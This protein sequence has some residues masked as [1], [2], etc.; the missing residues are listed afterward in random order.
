MKNNK[1]NFYCVQPI[2]IDK[3]NYIKLITNKDTNINEYENYLD[4]DNEML[5]LKDNRYYSSEVYDKILNINLKLKIDNE[6]LLPDINK[7]KEKYD[8]IEDLDME[9]TKYNLLYDMKLK[10][11]L[12]IR[13]I[14]L[15][16]K[17]KSEIKD[18]H[19]DFYNDIR[20][21]LVKETDECEI[22]Q[23]FNYVRTTVLDYCLLIVKN[24]EYIT[25]KEN[26]FYISNNTGN[27]TCFSNIQDNEFNKKLFYINEISERKKKIGKTIEILKEKYLFRGRFHTITINDE[28]SILRYFPIQFYM[29]YSWFFN[30][31][32]TEVNNKVIEQIGLNNNTMEYEE[33]INFLT[34]LL[35]KLIYAIYFNESFK[36]SIEGD[37]EDI[38]YKIEKN[39]NIEARIKKLEHYVFFYKEHLEHLKNEKKSKLIM[40]IEELKNEKRLLDD[41]REKDSLTRAFTRGIFDRDIDLL[42]KQNSGKLSLSFIDGDNFKKINDTYGHQI[43]DEVLKEIV[44]IIHQILRKNDIYGK[45]YRYGG[46]EFVL[47][48]QN[49]NNLPILGLL[50]MIRKEIDEK[51]FDFDGV[52]VKFTIS[53]GTAF[54]HSEDTVKSLIKRADDNVYKAKHNG[55]NRV[56]Y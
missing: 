41:R 8:F 31:F 47:V 16:I 23:W 35:S 20:N 27:I 48:I 5:W 2:S 50:E 53:I 22:S 10:Y 15:K 9:E 21:L 4:K 32:I 3:D 29:Q 42:I 56:E 6:E 55:K 19:Y 17:D 39:W 30:N 11:F 13:N 36:N 54:Y 37:S 14:S 1:L 44:S 52:K 45:V 51:D 34:I 46:E 38:Y 7:L 12:L 40:E 24:I 43:G 26:P 28:T 33:K 25:F 18:N 49:E